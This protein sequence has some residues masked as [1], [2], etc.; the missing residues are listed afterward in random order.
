[1]EKKI[2]YLV[3]W[4]ANLSWFDEVLKWRLLPV[5]VSSAVVSLSNISQH[6][7]GPP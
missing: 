3:F 5:S 2:Q 7:E 6:K 4:E 1:M